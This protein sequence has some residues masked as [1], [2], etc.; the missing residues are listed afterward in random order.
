MVILTLILRGGK[1]C[2]THF[3]IK[4]VKGTFNK[5]DVENELLEVCHAV[6]ADCDDSCPVFLLNGSECPDTKTLSGLGCDCFKDG[7]AMF[8]F[9]EENS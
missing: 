7:K 4:L 3:T 8:E 2:T 6:H 5:H 9:I 1:M